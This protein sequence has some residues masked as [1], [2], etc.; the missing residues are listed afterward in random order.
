MAES[1]PALAEVRLASHH[2]RRLLVCL[3]SLS[4]MCCT[5]Y[6][7]SQGRET[8]NCD[9][10]R[11]DYSLSILQ[12]PTAD[13]PGLKFV[14]CRR[15]TLHNTVE[16][17]TTSKLVPSPVL[18]GWLG[19]AA[20][21]LGVGAIS[22]DSI[23]Q[24]DELGIHHQ[25]AVAPELR[26]AA[27]VTAAA[28]AVALGVTWIIGRH[29]DKRIVRIP[30][31][32]TYSYPCAVMVKTGDGAVWTVNPKGGDEPGNFDLTSCVANLPSDV[33][34]AITIAI[35]D[36]PQV[37]RTVVVSKDVISALRAQAQARSDSIRRVAEMAPIHAAIRSKDAVIS[38][39]MTQ[40]EIE[41]SI[42]GES[43]WGTKY[44]AFG[45]GQLQAASVNYEL[46]KDTWLIL[47]YSYSHYAGAYVLDGV[48]YGT[49]GNW[50]WGFSIGTSA[51]PDYGSIPATY[52]GLLKR[53]QGRR[54]CEYY[55]EGER[56]WKE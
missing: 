21:S 13:N 56:K 15:Q 9:T 25:K 16:E 19:I 38:L 17:T 47:S 46:A 5:R 10:V 35:S 7:L 39:G 20:M 4:L 6:I 28:A 18:Q 27:G 1:L 33:D 29:V 37:L 53:E 30:S 14:A 50:G 55:W 2:R 45:V 44:H 48:T 11:T 49:Y 51:P 34:G 3:T 24:Q 54:Y 43:D 32:T 52:T 8:V 12:A 23:D 22:L 42:G 26:I 31:E 36:T 40:V 41:N